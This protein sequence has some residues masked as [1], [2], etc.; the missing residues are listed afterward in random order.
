M[1]RKLSHVALSLKPRPGISCVM[2]K[3]AFYVFPNVTQACRMLG[4][5][6][7][8]EFQNYL[9]EEAGVAV[10]GRTC[11]GSKN[12]GE[13]EEYIRLSYATSRQGIQ[14]GLERIRNAVTQNRCP[15]APK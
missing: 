15:A 6:T 14:E 4:F 13:T 12:A 8:K 11:F 10:L 5:R 7:S 9:L 1:G 2:P 3:G